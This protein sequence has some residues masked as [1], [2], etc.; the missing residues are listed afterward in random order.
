MKTEET[1]FEVLPK[2]RVYDACNQYIFP[3]LLFPVLPCPVPILPTPYPLHLLAFRT[4]N[5]SLASLSTYSEP[6]VTDVA[7]SFPPAAPSLSTPLSL[8]CPLSA[9]VCSLYVAAPDH[10][11]CVALSTVLNVAPSDQGLIATH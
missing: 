10:R 2:E 7:E 11:L 4:P 1:A 8:S 3:S 5:A 6:T 9:T